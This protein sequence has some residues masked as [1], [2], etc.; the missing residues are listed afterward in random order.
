MTTSR[1]A[2]HNALRAG[3]ALVA[4]AAL[5]KAAAVAACVHW[6]TTPPWIPH[7]VNDVNHWSAFLARVRE[8]AIPYVDVTIEY[9][10]G[11][12][13]FYWLLSPLLPPDQPERLILVHGTLMTLLDL[14]NTALFFAILRGIAPSRAVPLTLLFS[15]NLTSL[16]LSPARFEAVA[17]ALVLA[18]YLCHRRGRPLWAAFLW[19]LGSLVKWYP[20]FFLVAQEY[21]AYATSRERRRWLPALLI[22]A[23][24][25]AAAHLPFLVLDHAAHGHA[26]HALFPYWFHANRPLYWDTLLGMAT[27]WLGPQPLE[28]AASA[29][30]L[31][32]MAAAMLARPSL[33]LEYKG[34]LVCVAALLLN[35]VYSPQF[36]LW[37]YP[38]LLGG[39]A[40]EPAAR[41]RALLGVF[42]LL[43]ALNFLVYPWSFGL[44][45]QEVP[46][47]PGAAA[48]QG[49]PWTVVLTAAIV[50]R[51][52]VLVD[53]ARLLL[54]RRSPQAGQAGGPR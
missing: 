17:V 5:V 42:L 37:F 43:D 10:V 36:H 45:L 46:L 49:G 30:S 26:S 13:L 40:E 15:L 7:L 54:A 29:L 52:V 25:N 23:G 39:M 18:G 12:G 14:A 44:A 11:A 22:L 28:R 34:T 2:Q 24:V 50:L 8:G 51:A 9:P 35:R 27:L 16:S 32:L 31:G 6:R 33:R 1:G 4:L 3:L 38:L 19:A 47:R 48:S 20:A 41:F 53:L 21:R